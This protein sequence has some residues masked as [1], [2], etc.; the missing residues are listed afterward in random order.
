M[1]KFSRCPFFYQ[2]FQKGEKMKLSKIIAIIFALTVSVLTL[3]LVV[4]A[5]YSLERQVRE[6]QLEILNKYC[7]GDV[8][9]D[10][11]IAKSNELT[12]KLYDESTV[13]GYIS[14]EAEQIGNMFKGISHKVGATAQIYG[15]KAYQYIADCIVDYLDDYTALADIESPNNPD[16]KGYGAMVE[17]YSYQNEPSMVFKMYSDYG[18]YSVNANG[19]YWI[20][21]Q[22]NDGNVG[23]REYWYNGNLNNSQTYTGS[24]GN[25]GWY[26]KFYGDWRDPNNTEEQ[27]PTDDEF[28]QSEVLDFS[29]ASDVDLDKLINEISEALERAEP[30]LSNVEGL[31]NSIYFRLGQ[32]DSDNDNALL[33]EIN[34]AILSLA[35]SNS[36]NT[37]QLILKLDEI[38]QVLNPEGENENP[39]EQQ[40]TDLTGVIDELKEINAGIKGLAAIEVVENIWELTEGEQQLFN[41]YASLIPLIVDKL[42]IGLVQATMSDIESL[43]FTSSP[44]SDLTVEMYGSEYAVLSRDMFNEESLKYINLA[45]N[46]VTVLIIYAWCMSMR[47]KL[48]GVE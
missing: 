3:C 42:G 15:D 26:A 6:E 8:T 30:D 36:A 1:T 34:A 44:P 14:S 32:I 18:F 25:T 16:M 47:K 38:K 2:N 27:L 48:G 4:S 37:A 23:T 10:T 39:E 46:F 17:Y 35:N 24:Y 43:I 5:D 28:V 45:K 31:L 13:S 11:Y 22:M 7:K 12:Q 40:P 20:M 29:N 9:Y 21:S 33:A 19:S 41:E